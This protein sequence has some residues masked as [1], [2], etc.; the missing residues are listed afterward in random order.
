MQVCILPAL[1]ASLYSIR[2]Q[3]T[4]RPWKDTHAHE[5]V[6]LLNYKKSGMPFW[7]QFFLAPIPDA[8]GIVEYYLGI[9][10]DVTEEVEAA[11]LANIHIQGASSVQ[12]TFDACMSQHACNDVW[13]L[14]QPWP[15]AS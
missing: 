15:G 12:A 13:R 3:L 11:R 4:Q 7:N 10:I 1:L 9:Q 2:R 8:E 5:Q 6:C 14:R